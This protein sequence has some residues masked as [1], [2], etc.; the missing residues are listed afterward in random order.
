MG[1]ASVPSMLHTYNWKNA[2]P[3]LKTKRSLGYDD[4]SA[5][6]VKRAS[7][8]IFVILKHISDI[9]LAKRLFPD[10]VNIAR[11]TPIFKKGNNTLVTNYRPI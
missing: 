7:N 10:K 5:D 11:V 2:F 8:E 4:I 3:S 1:L 6:V 9:S